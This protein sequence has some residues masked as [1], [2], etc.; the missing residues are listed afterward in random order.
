MRHGFSLSELVLALALAGILLTIGLPRLSGSLDRIEVG[1]A[2][3]QI[4]GAHQR[5]RLL[6]ITTSRMLILSIDSVALTIRPQ[7]TPAPLWSAP[8][9]WSSG[10]TLAGP[11]RQFL[12]SPQGFSL[13][14]SNATLRLSRGMATRTVVVSR[15]GRVRVTR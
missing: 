15:L 12:F 4:A 6:A 9:P 13:G 11:P 2:A 7:D 14:L 8:G 3:S 10:V 1:A 5:A